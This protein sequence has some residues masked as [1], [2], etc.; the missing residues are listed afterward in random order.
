MAIGLEKSLTVSY[1][2]KLT[3]HQPSDFASRYLPRRYEN[4]FAHKSLLYTFDTFSGVLS[5]FSCFLWRLL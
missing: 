5:L 3:Y 1:I 2:V 4:K